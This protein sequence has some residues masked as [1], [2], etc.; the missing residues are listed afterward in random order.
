MS[1]SEDARMNSKEISKSAPV[2]YSHTALRGIA[3]VY[4][5]MNHLLIDEKGFHQEN[6]FFKC[7][8]WGPYSVDLFYILS[9]FV[10][11]WFYLENSNQVKWSSYFKARLARIAPLYYLTTLVIFPVLLYSWIRYGG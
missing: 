9:G 5:V 11:N 10:L 8:K 1:H 3:A 2:I 6:I 7:F 4:V